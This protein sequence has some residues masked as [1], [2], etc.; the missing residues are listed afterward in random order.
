[1]AHSYE[2]G[3]PQTRGP[4]SSQP[5]LLVS[6]QSWLGRR[7]ASAVRLGLLASLSIILD[8]GFFEIHSFRPQCLLAHGFP[9]PKIL[10]HNESEG[11]PPVYHADVKDN[12]RLLTPDGAVWKYKVRII[13]DVHGGSEWFDAKN[14]DRLPALLNLMTEE[15]DLEHGYFTHLIIAGNLLNF[16]A[17]PP[18]QEPPEP[19][20]LLQTLFLGREAK[21]TD[22][23]EHPWQQDK[24]KAG[25]WAE[26]FLSGGSDKE[27]GSTDKRK[28]HTGKDWWSS[29]DDVSKGIA[30]IGEG[31]RGVLREGIEVIWIPGNAERGLSNVWLQS[32]LHRQQHLARDAKITVFE[33]AA[34]WEQWGLR[35][36]PGQDIDLFAQDPRGRRPF[37]Y[38]LDR[39][40]AKHPSHKISQRMISRVALRDAYSS[41]RMSVGIGTPPLAK[42]RNCRK[43]LQ[44]AFRIAN[45]GVAIDMMETFVGGHW[46]IRLDEDGMFEMPANKTS[47]H[48]SVD[49]VL[50]EYQTLIQDW[51]DI[52][53]R[54]RT[55]ST[56]KATAYNDYALV[57]DEQESTEVLVFGHTLEDGQQFLSSGVYA[58]QIG[59]WTVGAGGTDTC[60]DVYVGYTTTGFLRPL[61]LDVFHF[62]HHH[63]LTPVSDPWRRGLESLSTLGVMAMITTCLIIVIFTTMV[64][65]LFVYCIRFLCP[66]SKLSQADVD[67]VK[68]RGNTAYHASQLDS[69]LKTEKEF[70]A[71]LSTAR[72]PNIF[73]LA[74]IPFKREVSV[75]TL[76]RQ[77]TKKNK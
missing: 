5:P 55:E 62:K 75:F 44:E 32:E 50:E 67:F 39:I 72:S 33:E 76:I 25:W 38:Y 71:Q 54:D 18:D 23:A 37:S 6:G 36:D 3:G 45:D 58:T 49:E 34:A 47:R 59:G 70:D 31:L 28:L 9:I 17:V 77:S 22:I 29:T 8:F 52:E 60:V 74:L 63:V 24:K 73:G 51:I 57:M 11:S 42:P 7:P 26:H 10:R 12:T 56:I 66:I 27:E 53:G 21:N 64:V 43:L 30:E 68:C 15:M 2:D 1:M 20:T 41:L 19:H 13:G 48:V 40:M 4:I 69:H 35:V 14:K 61:R 16:M 65:L 46:N